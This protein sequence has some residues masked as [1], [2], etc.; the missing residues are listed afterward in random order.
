[1]PVGVGA[2]V[3]GAVGLGAAGGGLT[4]AGIVLATGLNA[5][6]FLGLSAASA[7]LAERELKKAGIAPRDAVVRGGDFPKVIVYGEAV[8][9]GVMT[10]INQRDVGNDDFELWVALVHAGHES[11]QILG[12]YYEDSFIDFSTD[13]NGSGDLTD[14]LSP[15]YA[16][17]PGGSV[18]SARMWG[19]DGT[20]TGPNTEFQTAFSDITANFIL[21]GY[22]Y[23][24]HRWT[25]WQGSEE[26]FKGGEPSNI[27]ARLRGKEVYSP[28]LD[29][30]PGANPD[31]TSYFIWTDNPVLIAVDY[32][33]SYMNIP[34]ARFD[35][36]HVST[37]ATLAATTVSTPSG[38]QSRYT[39]NGAI[40]L[41]DTHDDN[42]EKILSCCLGHR[43]TVNGK[44]RVTIG[45]DITPTVSLDE[46]DI[47][48]FA[49]DSPTPIVIRQAVPR[50]QRFNTVAGTY[51]ASS[52]G[53]T[54]TEFQPQQDANLV[55]R[56]NGEE[57]ERRID[58]SMVT[59]EYQAQRIAQY[60]LEKADDE[61]VAEVPLRWSGLRLTPG[62]YC[63]V[64]Y[65]K[66]N[67][68]N[69][70]FRCEGVKIGEK[71]VP[72]TATLR[73]D[74]GWTDPLTGDYT[75]VLPDGAVVKPAPVV[76]APTNTTASTQPGVPG[77]IVDFTVPSESETWDE[78]EV[79]ASPDS[80]WSNAVKV[81]FKKR[82]SPFTHLTTSL[83]DPIG[84]GDTRYYWTRALR[85]GVASIRNP[86]SDTS[87]VTATLPEWSLPNL[88]PMGYSEFSTI[89][90]AD[91]TVSGAT[92]NPGSV[93]IGSTLASYVGS[94]NLR[95][96]AATNRMTGAD[97]IALTKDG[98]FNIR[99]NMSTVD[100]VQVVFY[101]NPQN[102]NALESTEI[103]WIL[104][105]ASTSASSSWELLD[106][107]VGVS[108]GSYA[109]ISFAIDTSS[110]TETQFRLT[111][112]ITNQNDAA[113]TG[114]DSDITFDGIMLVDTTRFNIVPD[115]P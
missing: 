52:A 89:N 66:F 93:S 100:E 57:I 71:G 94:Q 9:G 112:E 69:K 61:V 20:Q 29:T 72:V 25:L 76:P 3:A 83:I 77:I 104:Q 13:L 14:T 53:Y 43:S 63:Q 84:P 59:D 11:H 60:H 50:E 98:A 96:E 8:V 79:Y 32:M 30:T 111:L 10:Y 106:D 39:C 115:V 34:A 18:Y 28:A 45:G 17:S 85:N 108:Q 110:F 97:A 2:A 49:N 15:W 1:M 54:S 46:T 68:S 81:S 24:L 36:D 12:V 4:A 99:H 90:S 26:I 105:G 62:T 87:N 102:F 88:M 64:T 95:W 22:T 80:S 73:E 44:I 109:Q 91:I 35:W 51:F 7:A 75:Q 5:A 27:R 86:N 82:T 56:D 103:R 47:L 92:G 65:D 38:N 19:Y 16:F 42:L 113:T 107:I 101:V 31:N 114:F 58:L 41:G 33:R 70:V 21:Q 6:L 78:I 67:W 40:S 37:Q 48:A 23:T 74:N 55:T